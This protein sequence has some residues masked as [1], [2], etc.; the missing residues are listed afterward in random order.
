MTEEVAITLREVAPEEATDVKELLAKV[1]L[2]TDFVTISEA[3]LTLS[4]DLLASQLG[5]IYESDR[6]FLLAAYDGEKM[7]GL[8]SVKGEDCDSIAH[9][10]DVGVS[11]LKDYW[12]MGLGQLLLEEV[13]LWA[14]EMEVLHRLELRVQARNERAVHLY[15]KLGFEIE[16]TLKRGALSSEGDF[17][18]VYMM[19]LMI[20]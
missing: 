10:G 2:E 19:S 11:V 15:K 4:D 16:A 13:V 12:G 6:H 8:V 5:A 18:D 7:I 3:E 17:L 9:I 1:A 14:Q 20:N